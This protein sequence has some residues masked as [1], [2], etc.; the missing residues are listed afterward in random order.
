MPIIPVGLRGTIDI[1]PMHS[2]N[3]RPGRV[4]LTIGEP[5][6]TAG[7][8]VQDRARL[9]SELHDRVAALLR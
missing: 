8:T 1:L 5:I 4:V 9:T 7:L 2:A 3:V 6:P